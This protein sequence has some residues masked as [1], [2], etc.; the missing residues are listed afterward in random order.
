MFASLVALT[1]RRKVGEPRLARTGLP[2]GNDHTQNYIGFTLLE[3]ALYERVMND[4]SLQA[5]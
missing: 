5:A 4:P 2:G 1:L 3:K